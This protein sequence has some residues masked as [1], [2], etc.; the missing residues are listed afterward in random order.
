MDNYYKTEAFVFG[1]RDSGES[2][3]FFSVFTDEFGWL[4]IFAKAIRKGSSKLKS[5]IDIFY[6]SN[7]EF[8]QGKN[9]KTL[10]DAIK[11]HKL[12]NIYNNPNK[13]LLADRMSVLLGKFI[14]GQE[15]DEEI[16]NLI[17][18][19]FMKLDGDTEPDKFDFLYHYFLWNM[20]SILGYH[21]QTKKCVDCSG[22]LIPYN[23]YFSS[24]SG[25]IICKNCLNNDRAA[26]KINSDVVKILRIIFS[27]DWQ[28]LSRLKVSKQSMELLNN[29][30]YDATIFFSHSN[31][32]LND[33]IKL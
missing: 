3:R 5:G 2:D 27:H 16:F 11:I 29:I 23:I 18:D 24:K 9:K 14:K 13:F 6:F 1:K 28:T 22:V 10:T 26:K 7:I 12:S 25:G 33:I 21:I 31:C 20:L 15:K 17:K 30:S 32:K 4:D 19:V 8:V